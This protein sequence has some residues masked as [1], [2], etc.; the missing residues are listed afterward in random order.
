MTGDKFARV[1]TGLAV[2]TVAVVAGIV[3]FTHI[4]TLTLAHGYTLGAAR[5]LP[6]SVDGLIVAASLTCLTETRTRGS[7]RACPVPGWSSASWPP[8]RPT[9]R[10]A[11]SSASSARW[12][13]PGLLSRSSWRRKS[14]CGCCARPGTYPAPKRPPRQWRRYLPHLQPCFRQWRSACPSMCPQTCPRSSPRAR[15]TPCP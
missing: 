6:V 2:L 8:W 5:L 4:E 15:C 11:R 10:P 13:T 12:S 1:L 7:R 14:C 3:S 9:S